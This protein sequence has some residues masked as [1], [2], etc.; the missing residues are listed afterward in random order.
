MDRTDNST[1][2]RLAN[3]A[4]SSR[5]VAA[6][7]QRQVLERLRH[8]S[9]LL[10]SAFRI[11]VIGYRVGWDAVLGL[12]PVLGD[13][14]G[15]LF[16]GYIVYEAARLGVPKKVLARMIFNLALDAII[17]SIPLIGS[18]FDAVWKANIRNMR[19]LERTLNG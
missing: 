6:I 7:D 11:P 18:L 9:Y 16:S 13:A 14:V 15:M 2:V 3:Q 17:G 8:L 10:D 4:K 19:L 1:L 5:R 12:V